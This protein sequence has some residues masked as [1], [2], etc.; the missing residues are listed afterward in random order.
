MSEPQSHRRA[1]LGVGAALATIAVLA[2]AA[3]D[4]SGGS[5]RHVRTM[6][7]LLAEQQQVLDRAP[8]GPSNGDLVLLRGQLLNPKTRAP[9]GAEIGCTSW[10]TRRTRTAASRPSCSRRMLH[11]ARPGGSAHD[12]D[13]L[14]L[15]REPPRQVERSRAAPAASSAPVERSSRPP[16]PTGSLTWSSGSRTDRLHRGRRTAGRPRLTA[17]RPGRAAP[18]PSRAP[19]RRGRR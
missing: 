8:A 6:H 12:R 19:R 14:R 9:V 5:A 7:F 16:G 4:A 11:E 18:W 15:R 13:D 1:W 10:P 2:T 17:G 3:L